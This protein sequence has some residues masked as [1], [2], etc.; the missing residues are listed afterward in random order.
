MDLGERVG[1]GLMG[2]MWVCEGL[3]IWVKGL[4]NRLGSVGEGI[5]GD[6]VCTDG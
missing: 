5:T 6:V 2:S 3:C 4:G 1:G